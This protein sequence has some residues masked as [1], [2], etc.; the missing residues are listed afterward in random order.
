MIQGCVTSF[1][2]VLKVNRLPIV[3]KPID[4]ATLLIPSRDTAA[5][6]N[7]QDRRIFS[8]LGCRP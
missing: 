3:L 6:L 1:A 8:I 7:A 4:L 5:L 2:K